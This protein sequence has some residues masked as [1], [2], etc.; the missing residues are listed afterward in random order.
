MITSKGLRACQQI[1]G[2]LAHAGERCEIHFDQIDRRIARL[3]ECG[4][5]LGEI[6][7]SADDSAAVRDDRACG[8]DTEAGRYASYQDALAREIYAFEDF[9]SG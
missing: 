6:A 7:R 4:P 5:R 3:R 1:V 2:R 9:I 8:L